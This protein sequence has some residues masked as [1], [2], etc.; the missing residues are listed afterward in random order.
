MALRVAEPRNVTKCKVARAQPL[1][2]PTLH[3]P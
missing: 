1:A 3:M 2:L